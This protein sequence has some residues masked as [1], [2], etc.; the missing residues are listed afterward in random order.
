MSEEHKEK[1]INGLVLVIVLVGLLIGIIFLFRVF[2][3][4]E[5][6]QQTQT[7]SSGSQQSSLSINQLE[8]VTVPDFSKSS[9]QNITLENGK[10]DLSGGNFQESHIALDTD[11][12]SYVTGDFNNDGS[13]DIAAVIT[14][15]GGGSGVFYYLVVFLNDNGTPKYLTA[16]FLGDRT[17]I[18]SIKYGDGTFSADIITQGPND[19]MCC[20]TLQKTLHFTIKNDELVSIDKTVTPTY[21]PSQPVTSNYSYY[22]HMTFS[23]AVE[24]QRS[25]YVNGC[26]SSGGMWGKCNCGFDYLISNYGLVWLI[27]EEAYINVNG[28]SSPE[29]RSA[30]LNAT[31]YCS[32]YSN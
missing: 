7:Q 4:Q 28:V 24:A 31:R 27:D 10:Y 3:D 15:N 5:Q 9:Q 32:V 12:P 25:S 11:T 14:F 20:G 21:P 30:S 16:T 29:L 8:N 17:K 23:T 22:T 18:N 6:T 13:L 26:T 1:Q 2:N 19:P